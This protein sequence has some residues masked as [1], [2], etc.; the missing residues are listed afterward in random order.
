[1]D[2]VR[3]KIANERFFNNADLLLPVLKDSDG[4]LF[5][6]RVKTWLSESYELTP[7]DHT[8]DGVTRSGYN[9]AELNT[10]L[11]QK[12]VGIPGIHGET[13][14]EYGAILIKGK[15]GFDFSLFDEE[16]NVIKLRNAFIGY[17]GR[18]N[19]EEPLMNLNTKVLKADGTTYYKRDWRRKIESLGGT[20]GKN[21]E[22]KKRCYTVVGEIQFGNWA[23][24]RH[25]LLRL[26]NSAIDGEIDYYIYITATGT[27]EKKL[28]SGIVSYSDV[29]DLFEENR[30]LI[31]TPVWVIGIDMD[32]T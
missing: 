4:T 12:M 3:I 28:S 21:I 17:P 11:R 22:S 18:Y 13:Y 20:N 15:K 14:V 30:Q 27:L 8:E 24:V 6:N 19:G 7:K 2:N 25:D 31:K 29:V 1:M 16:Y 23:I 10:V 5:E 9:A 32:I 26:L